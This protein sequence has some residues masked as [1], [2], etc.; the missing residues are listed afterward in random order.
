VKPSEPADGD[1]WR[2][3]SRCAA[4]DSLAFDELVVRHQDRLY[5]VCARLLRDREEARDAVQEVLLKLFRKAGA[6]RPDG[7]LFT[8]LY[9][10]A[11]NHCL[12]RMRRHRLVRFLP[13]AGGPP[14]DEGERAYDPPDSG[15]DPARA[16]QAKERWRSLKRAIEALPPG[17]RVV[18]LLARFE[19]LSQR[20]IA[21]ALGI[22][23]GAV[24]SRL[25]RAMR[26]LEKAQEKNGFGVS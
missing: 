25:V 23:E 14:E 18:L 20:Q 26:A 4:G 15:A 6:M 7:Q 13:F 8:L 19:G 21:Q 11:V 2:L 3:L 24:E 10:I 22:T 12:N 1:D 9:R 5:R 16:A 17:Q